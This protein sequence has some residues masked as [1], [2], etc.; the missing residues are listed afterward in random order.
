[1]KEFWNHLRLTNS[2]RSVN[3]ALWDISD[4]FKSYIS[5]FFPLSRAEQVLT[6]VSLP[7]RQSPVELM[8][9]NNFQASFRNARPF[10][11]CCA[12]WLN[13]FLANVT[14]SADKLLT[15][16]LMNMSRESLQPEKT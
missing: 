12:E 1:M 14:A 2:L 6:R 9:V 11:C 4:G 8:K 16:R 10:I 3:S 5:S 13:M 7:S 15:I